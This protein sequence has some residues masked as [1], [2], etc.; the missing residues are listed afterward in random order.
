MRAFGNIL[1][2]WLGNIDKW[3]DG[4]FC[5]AEVLGENRTAYKLA[6]LNVSVS[7]KSPKH[8]DI[9][10]GARLARQQSEASEL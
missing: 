2:F 10:N 5:E 4:A 3:F 7:V 6:N 9:G 8:I 1:W